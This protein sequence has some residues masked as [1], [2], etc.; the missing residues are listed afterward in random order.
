MP[1]LGTTTRFGR[2]SELMDDIDDWCG[3]RPPRK[4]PP[5]P[6]GVRDLLVSIAI[7]NLASQLGDAK[8]RNQIQGLAKSAYANAGKQISG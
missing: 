8:L 3:T 4:F 7:H 1:T 5:K 2:L 6:G